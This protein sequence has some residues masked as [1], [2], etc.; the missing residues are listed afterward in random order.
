MFLK[1]IFPLLPPIFIMARKG[2]DRRLLVQRFFN[3]V[4]EPIIEFF[5]RLANAVSNGNSH[6]FA[7]CRTDGSPVVHFRGTANSN[8]HIHCFLWLVCIFGPNYPFGDMLLSH[9][10]K[11]L[12]NS[13]L[14]G[15]NKE[16]GHLRDGD[17]R[18]ACINPF[19]Y[20]CHESHEHTLRH[21]LV[22]DFNE[23]W[24]DRTRAVDEGIPMSLEESMFYTDLASGLQSEQSFAEICMFIRSHCEFSL[25]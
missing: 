18:R 17:R 20:H 10:W 4:N 11:L 13:C 1:F 12:E 6:F 25:I 19:H 3:A 21:L 7:A 16:T 9:V 2:D 8:R 22:Q 14:C 15:I 24:L 5:S 23:V